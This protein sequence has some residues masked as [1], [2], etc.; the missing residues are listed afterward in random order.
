MSSIL[1]GILTVSLEVKLLLVITFTL[2][3]LFFH[4]NL[5]K[6]QVY[7][8]LKHLHLFTYILDLGVSSLLA[9]IVYTFIE[10]APC[11]LYALCVLNHQ[12]LS[13]QEIQPCLQYC[14]N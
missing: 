8:L 2:T 12:F 13:A 4:V 10:F 11:T 14:I 5:V 1:L 3:D 6:I 7:P 9:H